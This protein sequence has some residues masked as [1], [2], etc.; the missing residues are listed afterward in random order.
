MKDASSIFVKES[1]I[2]T[3]KLFEV[4]EIDFEDTT[5]FERQV[6][7]IL[8]FGMI[9]AYAMEEKISVDTVN[10]TAEYLLI[11]VFRYSKEQSRAFLDK[12]IEGTQKEKSSV[13]NYIIHQGIEMYYEY[14]KDEEDKMFDRIMNIY[15][16]LKK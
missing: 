10:I 8:S 12:M 6:L 13:Y 2:M 16:A 15:L 9:N 7:S 5:E 11:K 1:E 3:N 4:I 14:K